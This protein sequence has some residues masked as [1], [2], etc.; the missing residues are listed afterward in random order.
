MIKKENWK[1]LI[2]SCNQDFDVW[3]D[4]ED[5]TKQEVRSWNHIIN[6]LQ[7]VLNY[8]IRKR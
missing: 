7:K 4:E 1:G 8:F 5:K 2:W 6:T 3:E